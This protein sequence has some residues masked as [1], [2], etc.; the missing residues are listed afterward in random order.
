MFE[1][2][3]ERER[4]E[5]GEFLPLIVKKKMKTEENQ[6]D[7]FKKFPRS[8]D[9]PP[10]LSGSFLVLPARL[11]R[12]IPHSR[13]GGL[14]KESLEAATAESQGERTRGVKER[15][16]RRRSVRSLRFV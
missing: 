16:G 9:L 7:S 12:F 3:R 11:C 4:A 5:R 1:R 2:E 13:A 14:H 10:H 6:R 8:I 15:E